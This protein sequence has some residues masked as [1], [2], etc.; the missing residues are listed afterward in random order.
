MNRESLQPWQAD[1]L[2][3]TLYPGMNY[4]SRLKRRMEQVGF[5]PDDPLYRHVAA[6]YDAM[7]SLRVELH[8]LSCRSDVGKVHARRTASLGWRN[9]LPGS[10]RG[11]CE[12]ARRT[13]GAAGEFGRGPCRQALHGSLPDARGQ[14]YPCLQSG[15][16][17]A[18][19]ANSW[20]TTVHRCS[21]VQL[22]QSPGSSSTG[23]NQGPEISKHVSCVFL[24]RRFSAS[25]RR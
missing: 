10:I 8:Y 6:A 19:R 13:G 15:R 22:S 9:G 21:Q 18:A 12:G 11:D 14:A 2:F 3:Q 16:E 5:L 20:A 7:L 23:R 25:P 1:R 24:R 4:L 17:I